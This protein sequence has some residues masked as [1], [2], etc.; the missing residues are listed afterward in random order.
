MGITVGTLEIDNR[1]RITIPKEERER[2]GLTP[3]KIV[4]I[5]EK[6]GALIIKRFISPEKFISE[7]KGCITI[8]NHKIDPLKL[9]KMW[10]VKL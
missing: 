3:G 9:K 8:E 6:D 2:L 1:G 7:L 4:L 10:G 5:R